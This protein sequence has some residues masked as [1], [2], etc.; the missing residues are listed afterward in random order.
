MEPTKEYIIEPRRLDESKY[1]NIHTKI[2]IIHLA[3]SIRVRTRIQMGLRGLK[4]MMASITLPRLRRKGNL[5]N[6]VA[7]IPV[8]IGPTV[9][10]KGE[11]K[12]KEK[13]RK[14]RVSTEAHTRETGIQLCSPTGYM[15]DLAATKEL[16]YRDTKTSV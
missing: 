12:R 14:T 6:V 1:P 5:A 11:R 16:Y 10:E 7:P 13:R 2:Q 8:K 3:N 15:V 4:I 9:A